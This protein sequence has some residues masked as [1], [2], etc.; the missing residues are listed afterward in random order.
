VRPVFR[1]RSDL[2]QRVETLIISSWVSGG[3]SYRD[4]RGDVGRGLRRGR[5]S[6]L[7]Q[8]AE[9][10]SGHAE[11]DE[12]KRRGWTGPGWTTNRCQCPLLDGRSSRRTPSQG[13]AVL[14]SGR[15]SAGVPD[16]A[17]RPYGCD[18]VARCD[19]VRYTSR[20]LPCG[21]MR[22]FVAHRLHGNANGR[23]AA[24]ATRGNDSP[25]WDSLDE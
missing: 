25:T 6:H 15:A 5:G 3:L 7:H 2:V 12:W 8:S 19:H 13:R 14:I 20:Y 9:P 18:Q 4:R 24:I 22:G 10:A 16:T 23:N 21:P 17:R 11:F 1:H